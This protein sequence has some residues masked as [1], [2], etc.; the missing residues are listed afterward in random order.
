MNPDEPIKKGSW[1][2]GTRRQIEEEKQRQIDEGHVVVLPYIDCE[3]PSHPVL[4][5]ADLISEM[6]KASKK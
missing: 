4:D 2:I 5:M 3:I 6:L 1:I